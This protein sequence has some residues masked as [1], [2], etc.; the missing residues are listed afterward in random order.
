[1]RGELIGHL[2][3]KRQYPVEEEPGEGGDW[4]GCDRTIEP[5]NCGLGDAQKVAAAHRKRTEDEGTSV[6]L[7]LQVKPAHNDTTVRT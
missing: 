5:V 2:T 3:L 1:M 6:Q 4:M 7:F